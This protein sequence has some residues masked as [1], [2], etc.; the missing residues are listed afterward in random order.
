MAGDS[1]EDRWR[2][3]GIDEVRQRDF[4]LDSFKWLK[5]ELLED[6]PPHEWWTPS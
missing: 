2:S 3:F 5:E 1:K 6:G 4:K